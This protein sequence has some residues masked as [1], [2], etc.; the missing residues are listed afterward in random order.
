MKVARF[1]A[2]IFAAAGLVLMLGSVGLCLYSLGKPAKVLE[3]PQEA[4][5]CTEQL[6]ASFAQGDYA[7]AGKCLYGQPDL[8]G[9]GG[10][11]D[12]TAALFW[13]AFLDSVSYSFAGDCY[14]ADGGFARQVTV[15]TLDLSAMTADFQSRC[16]ALLSQKV[17]TATEMS[18]LYDE[19]NNFRQ[20]L[21]DSVVE[22]AAAE[23]A[24]QPSQTKT[25]DITLELV[26]WDGQWWVRPNGELL[27]A[28][29]A[30][31]A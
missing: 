31:L 21:I 5:D 28:M 14:A 7:G 22:Q 12:P 8:G 20:D 10:P 30:D 15:T 29:S 2:A 9:M 27:R 23:A 19:D 6:M 3:Y 1:F 26:F 13:D 17:E 11:E 16:Q 25:Y 18:E 4:A 24:S